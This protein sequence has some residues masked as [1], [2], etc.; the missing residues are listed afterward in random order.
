MSSLKSLVRS[1]V[2]HAARVCGVFEL[3]R[4]RTR[5]A[6]RILCYHGGA[7]HDEH[8]YSP[9]TFIRDTVFRR[10]MAH[11]QSKGYPIVPLADAVERLRA[12]T[13]PDYATVITIDDGWVGTHERLLPVLESHGF[14]STLYVTSYYVEKQ[15]QVFNM[16]VGYLLWKHADQ[17]VN[18]HALDSSLEGVFALG[19]VSARDRAF[20]LIDE[21][22]QQLPDAAAR[23]ALAER[24][25]TL[26]GNTDLE[27]CPR[28]FSLM[29]PDEVRDAQA[30]G[31]DI[32][33]HTH[34]HHLPADSEAAM[35]QE[36]DDNAASLG[37]ITD[38]SFD[39]FCY[40]SGIYEDVQLPWLTARGLAT[41]TTVAHGFNYPETPHLELRRLLDSD[42]FSDIEF[43][44]ELCGFFEV[45]RR[46]RYA[47]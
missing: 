46:R 31:M 8:R 2:L 42:A 47:A 41:A 32:Q 18:L 34:R 7:I 45:F 25:A 43:E 23:Q 37:R 39:H 38:K 29:S 19:D 26:L 30:R 14:E 27:R 24:L 6:L 4:R 17:S 9:G 40:P 15:T 1:V 36:L 35:N 44:A 21:F 33:L 12:G 28:L 11:V 3:C 10:R 20:R 16:F 22:G 13:L 5:R